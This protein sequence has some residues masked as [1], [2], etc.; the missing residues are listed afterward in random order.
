M[1]AAILRILDANFNRAREGLRV[2]EEHARM[3]LN[4]ARL[5]TEIKQLRHDLAAVGQSVD[6]ASLLSSRDTPGDVGTS[7]STDSEGVRD[8]AEAVA[9]AACKRVAES[10]R[11]IEEYGKTLRLAAAAVDP[12]GTAS[13]AT[14]VEAIRYRVYT[15]E[16]SLLVTVPRRRKLAD[17]RLHVL[18]TESLCRRPWR[19][20]A[21]AVLEA[22][23]GAI[24]L[25]EKGM[26]DAVLLERAR[27]LREMTR[28][29]DALLIINDRPDIARL[30]GADGV[31]LGRDDLPLRAARTIAG[32]TVLIGATAHDE[33]EIRAAMD[34]GADYLGVG[35]MFTSPT[36]PN[37]SVNGPELLA[38][39]FRI[40]A[41]SGVSALPL[42]AIGGIG[43][44]KVAKLVATCPQEA[45]FSLAVCGSVIGALDPG[46]EVR[47][48]LRVLERE[49]NLEGE[50][51][52]A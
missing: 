37:V 45:R 29:R 11:C 41:S 51:T 20:V 4:D 35:P 9:A 17:A 23:A 18:L 21:A 28:T 10:L 14:R 5:S 38:R 16:Q 3:V 47:A 15:A 6:M 40:V 43:T 33:A 19:D 48:I 26:P 7:I 39:A 52:P 34:A 49:R 24:Q 1:D 42:V 31:H 25:R 32:P 13:I 36:K 30:C 50:T 8:G 27:E 46:A 2:M 12:P 22:G 44:S